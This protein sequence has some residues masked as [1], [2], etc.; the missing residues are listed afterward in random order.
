MDIEMEAQ[1]TK[2][3][4]DFSE[5]GDSVF[6]HLTRLREHNLTGT[7]YRCLLSM[8]WLSDSHGELTEAPE[9]IAESAGAN[10]RVVR[11]SIRHLLK[12]GLVKKGAPRQFCIDPRLKWAGSD[13]GRRRLM[14][15]WE[16]LK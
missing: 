6:L 9:T 13:R 10:V 2:D 3:G 11:R 4:Q 16:K 7:D 14:A 15:A 8:L 5:C 12:A 1:K